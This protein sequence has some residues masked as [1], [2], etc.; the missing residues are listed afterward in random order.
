MF[1]YIPSSLK[2]ALKH[3]AHVF[4]DGVKGK[5]F[6]ERGCCSLKERYVGNAKIFKDYEKMDFLKNYN[7]SLSYTLVTK[8]LYDAA[9]KYDDIT[10]MQYVDINTWLKNELY[11]WAESTIKNSM[12]DEYINKENTLKMLE[13]HR[14]GHIDYSRKLWTIITFI[15]WHK[16]FVEE[17]KLQAKA[18]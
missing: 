11:S 14:T 4:P 12:A 3:I 17:N 16:V 6:I 10:K 15:L 13:V 5:S 9:T 7:K 1:S 2:H 18:I 8:P